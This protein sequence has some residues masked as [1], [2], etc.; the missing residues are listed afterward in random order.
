MISMKM[1][2]LISHNFTVGFGTK[3]RDQDGGRSWFSIGP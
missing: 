1:K 3:T 2:I